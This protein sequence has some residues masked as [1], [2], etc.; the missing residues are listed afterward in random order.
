VLEHSVQESAS[1]YDDTFIAEVIFETGTARKG[2]DVP[3]RRALE[4]AG[5]T[6]LLALVHAGQRP[7]IA[8]HCE[9]ERQ[10][11]FTK[12]VQ[13]R[14]ITHQATESPGCIR[15][16][17]S[18]HW[19]ADCG[20]SQPPSPPHGGNRWFERVLPPRSA[21]S[22]IAT[23]TNG[24]ELRPSGAALSFAGPIQNAVVVPNDD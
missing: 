12:P 5:P 3:P 16:C 14:A 10:R 6:A 8:F 15:Q 1:I 11:D 23:P 4:Y 7:I 9:D 19:I 20:P 21:A 22:R 2:G 18:E 13:T 17:P 24:A